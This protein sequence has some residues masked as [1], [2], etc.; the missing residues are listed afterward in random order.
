MPLPA[1]LIEELAHNPRFVAY[2][3]GDPDAQDEWES[4]LA[5][6]PDKAPL[7]FEAA[8]LVCTLHDTQAHLPEEEINQ[9]WNDLASR[10]DEDEA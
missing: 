8:D 3:L 2:V 7:F 1:H 9:L 10:L 4:W 5:E 6:H